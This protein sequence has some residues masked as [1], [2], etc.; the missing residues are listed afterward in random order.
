MNTGFS[1][2]KGEREIQMGSGGTCTRGEKDIDLSAFVLFAFDNCC[3]SAPGLKF[4]AEKFPN[5]VQQ[6]F[7]LPLGAAGSHG[8]PQEPMKIPHPIY[9][10]SHFTISDRWKTLE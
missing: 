7:C 10:G 3:V 6:N 4:G 5:G 8:R 9:T 1:S 2:N